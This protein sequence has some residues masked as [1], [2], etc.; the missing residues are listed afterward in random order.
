[1]SYQEIISLVSLLFFGFYI[2]SASFAKNF[3]SRIERLLWANIFAVS[4]AAQEIIGH[5]Q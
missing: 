2:L 3:W 1:M 5:L 4:L